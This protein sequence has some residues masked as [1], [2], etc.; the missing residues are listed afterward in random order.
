MNTMIRREQ[1]SFAWKEYQDYVVRL[2]ARATGFAKIFE[3]LSSRVELADLVFVETGCLRAL[4]WEGDGCSSI[5]FNQFAN[6]TKS[7]FIS[8]DHDPNH[9]AFARR[10][11]PGARVLCGDSVATLYQLHRKLKQMDLLYLDS[12]DVDW[13]KPHLSALHHLKELCA[14]SPMLRRSSIV[15]IDDNTEVS[16]KGLY[17]RDYLHNIGAKAVFECY[18]LG[19]LMP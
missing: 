6:R 8:I 18:Q 10:H 15:F 4:N 17:I 11:C 1:S 5:L 3:M 16:G 13:K 2:G 12:Y 9:C 14:A 7:K 19:F